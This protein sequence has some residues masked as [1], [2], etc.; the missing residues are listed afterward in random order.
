LSEEIDNDDKI[1]ELLSRN[2]AYISKT[3]EF[4]E[5]HSKNPYGTLSMG[6]AQVE[7]FN[8]MKDA[9][10]HVDKILYKA[11]HTGKNQVV[12]EIEHE[13]QKKLIPYTR[14]ILSK[15][16]NW[17]EKSFLTKNSTLLVL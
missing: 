8:V 9:F 2:E 10:D 1:S 4:F 15:K 11:K 16:P 6:I 3:K 5:V 13:G 14:Y 7:R 17:K 12:V